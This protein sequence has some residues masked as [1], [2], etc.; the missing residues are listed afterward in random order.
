[1]KDEYIRLK[2]ELDKAKEEYEYL[3]MAVQ[4]FKEQE[5]DLFSNNYVCKK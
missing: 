3:K 4:F 5:D 2:K 1:M